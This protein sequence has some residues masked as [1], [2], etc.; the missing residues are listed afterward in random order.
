MLEKDIITSTPVG[1]NP[2]KDTFKKAWLIFLPLLLIG[3]LLEQKAGLRSIALGYLFSAISFY[4]LCENQTLILAKQNKKLAFTGL[5]MRLG[6]YAMPISLALYFN[7]YF[8]L[9]LVLISLVC[10][11]F[12][13]VGTELYKSIK[14]I[15]QG[16]K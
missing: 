6:F 14:N 9:P 12:L 15:K 8:K 1:Y 13:F 11:Q 3:Y 7:N 2:F 16:K 10:F 4:F 5:F